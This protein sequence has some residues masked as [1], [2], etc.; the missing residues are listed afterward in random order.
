V[1]ITDFCFFFCRLTGGVD[2]ILSV[3]VLLIEI[4]VAM[5]LISLFED[6]LL[7]D[8]ARLENEA[9]GGV[10]CDSKD[11]EEVEGKAVLC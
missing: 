3:R 11:I 1:H 10:D 2:A 6:A 5:V 9:V 7:H 8:M 4:E